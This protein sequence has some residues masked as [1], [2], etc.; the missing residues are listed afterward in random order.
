MN[1][2]IYKCTHTYTYT[3]TRGKKRMRRLVPEHEKFL[4]GG[5]DDDDGY[6]D[7]DEVFCNLQ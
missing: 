6:D 2:Y 4:E 5:G 1:A 3:C 7:D